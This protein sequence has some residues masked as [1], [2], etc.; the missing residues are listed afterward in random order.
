MQHQ[1]EQATH[2][3]TSPQLLSKHQLMAHCF[4]RSVA[5]QDQL[6]HLLVP[7]QQDLSM[8]THLQQLGVQ[9]S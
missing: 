7:K 2:T 4:S 3:S 9:P 8:S 6:R 5:S 1:E